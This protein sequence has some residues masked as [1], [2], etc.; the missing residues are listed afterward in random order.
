MS[1][2]LKKK[3]YNTTKGTKRWRKNLDATELEENIYVA[4]KQKYD[5]QQAQEKI[6]KNEKVTFS[7]N[8][9][10]DKKM[11]IALEKDRFHKKIDESGISE[12]EMRKYKE[13]AR[14][15][16][17]AEE[18]AKTA[19]PKVEKIEEEINDEDNF[20]DAWEEAP[21][22]KKPLISKKQKI[23]HVI[24]PTSGMSYNPSFKDHQEVIEEA[25]R[26]EDDDLKEKNLTKVKKLRKKKKDLKEYQRIQRIKLDLAMNPVQK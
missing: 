5:E 10:G 6:K 22:R 1:N 26:L 7:I 11:K 2:L 4:E 21:A 8:T 19:P 15:M 3:N 24:V 14:K 23:A 25:I 12:I 9:T 20:E 17:K 13:L 18:L 16:K